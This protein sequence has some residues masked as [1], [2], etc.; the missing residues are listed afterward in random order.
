[1]KARKL[2]LI[3]ILAIIT[4]VL[5]TT[6]YLDYQGYQIWK[7]Q[8]LAKYPPPVQPYIDFTPYFNTFRG[9]LLILSS[10]VIYVTF[11]LALMLQKI[12]AKD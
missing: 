8:E 7:E 2:L 6:I 12:R 3:S 4:V 9:S 5:A 10:V 1:M 11:G